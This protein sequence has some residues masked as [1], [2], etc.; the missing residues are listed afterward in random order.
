MNGELNGKE[1]MG[2]A[3]M[4]ERAVRE[5]E[6][7]RERS[8]QNMEVVEAEYGGGAGSGCIAIWA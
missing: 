3:R 5:R 2:L 1:T 7:E 8:A 6:R 4:P